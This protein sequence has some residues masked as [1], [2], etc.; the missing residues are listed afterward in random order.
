MNTQWLKIDIQLF[1][2]N[3]G[4][5]EKATAKRRSDARKEGQVLQSKEINSVLVL[6]IAFFALKLLGSYMYGQMAAFTRKVFMIYTVQKGLLDEG[7]LWPLVL[8]I[9]LV[10]FKVVAPFMG[11]IL[12]IALLA[13]YAQVG[14]L[15]TTKPLKPKFNKLNPIQGMKRLFSKNTLM[16]LAKA[17]LKIAIVGIIA[18][19]YMRDETRN[20]IDLMDREIGEIVVYIGHLITNVALRMGIILIL[21]AVVDYIFQWRKFEKD[22]MMSK[23]EVKE[24]HK[25][26]EGN[27]QIKS[28]IRQK[29]RESSIRRM[30]TE[31]PK[32]DVV[33]TNPT[34]FAVALKYDAKIADAP[35]VLAK[36]QDY[37][38]LRIKEIAK[39]NKVEIVENKALARAL[40]T[41]TDIGEAIPPELFQAVAE[42]LAFVYS[43]K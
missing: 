23:Q 31:I 8:E 2:D 39:E 4:K 26:A 24:E 19:Y 14:F 5:T 38:A 22:L 18:Y 41:S 29:Q 21:L 37:V 17:I 25:Q 30:M 6:I 20:I 36:G 15:F 42:V 27:P 10:M 1:A 11:V 9:F 43:L 12:V 28:K 33:I 34:H 35:I 3:D 7:N 13:N 40:Y 16:E 32:A